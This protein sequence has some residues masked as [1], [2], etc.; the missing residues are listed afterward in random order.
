MAVEI[1]CP[2]SP[3]SNKTMLPV[4]YECL[5]YY[6]SQVLGEMKVLN[7]LRTMVVLCSPESLTMC[8]VVWNRGAMEKAL[9]ALIAIFLISRMHQFLV[10]Y[11]HK[12]K[13]YVQF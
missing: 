11:I 6:A 12:L 8:Y 5:H 4:N 1:K 10:N 7:G 13:N 3:I 2:F 9:A